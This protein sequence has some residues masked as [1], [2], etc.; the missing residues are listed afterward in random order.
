M[1]NRYIVEFWEQQ[2]VWVR[3]RVEVETDK[4]PTA[5]NMREILETESVNYIQSDYNWESSE[6][7]DYDFETDFCVEND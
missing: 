7:H 1:P 5:E 3:H 2:S 6:N 4:V